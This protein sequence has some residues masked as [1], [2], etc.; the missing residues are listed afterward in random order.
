MCDPGG[1]AQGVLGRLPA[2]AASKRSTR[3]SRSQDLLCQ[4]HQGRQRRHVYGAAGGPHSGPPHPHVGAFTVLGLCLG[5]GGC[6]C[7]EERPCP[8]TRCFVAGQAAP[9]GQQR[10]VCRVQGAPPAGVRDGNQGKP[11]VVGAGPPTDGALPC[12]ERERTA[13]CRACHT[14]RPGHPPQV[15][16]NGTKTPIAAV[17]EA[18]RKLADETGTI[19][20]KFQASSMQSSSSRAPL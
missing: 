11:R 1:R 4:G 2:I 6:S 3:A 19:R 17:G 9:D 10:A 16:T 20:K 15:Q 7:W 13:Q 14:A 18:I 8:T 12:H 5:E